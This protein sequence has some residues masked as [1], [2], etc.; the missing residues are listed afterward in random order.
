M[1]KT[2]LIFSGPSGAGKSTLIKYLLS[3]LKSVDLTVSC[4]TRVPREGE[5]NGLDYHFI[6]HDKFETL[7]KQNEFIEHVSCYGNRYGTLK[8]AVNDVLEKNEICIL[9]LE[10]EGAYNV[11]SK[12][13]FEFNCFGILVLPPSLKTLKSRLQNRNSET[14]ESLNLRLK[15][16]FQ[17]KQIAKYDYIIINKNL[18]EAKAEL[19]NKI[20]SLY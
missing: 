19:I 6:T 5:K 15:E 4:T 20:R 13:I 11:L 12:N 10:F 2:I 9:D 18:D 1:N 8:K 17:P 14:I 7:V 16:S 3:N